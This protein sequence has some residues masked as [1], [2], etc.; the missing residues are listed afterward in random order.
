MGTRPQFPPQMPLIVPTHQINIDS[1]M[2][3]FKRQHKNNMV[4]EG[5]WKANVMLELVD[6][7]YVSKHKAIRMQISIK[8]IKMPKIPLIQLLH[9]ITTCSNITLE[10]NHIRLLLI[11]EFL[12]RIII[13]SEYRR[14]LFKKQLDLSM[15]KLI[16]NDN[17]I[18]RTG[19]KIVR[20]LL[21]VIN[22]I[23][24]RKT[25]HLT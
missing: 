4:V 13:Y 16:T 20:N 17:R 12:K 6:A 3:I 1:P 24:L 9:I 11:Q 8:F 5:F 14:V 21:I 10:I 22:Y 7:F 2:V 15:R 19:I 25:I 18:Q 23:E